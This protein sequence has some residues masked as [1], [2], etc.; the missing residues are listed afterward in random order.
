MGA[1]ATAALT[2]HSWGPEEERGNWAVNLATNSIAYFLPSVVCLRKSCTEDAENPTNL[3]KEAESGEAAN[4]GEPGIIQ[5]SQL[6]RK[7]L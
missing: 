6:G 1:R 5:I 4:E 7:P 2:L 3:A